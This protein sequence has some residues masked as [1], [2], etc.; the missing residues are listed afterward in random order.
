V[1]V[2]VTKLFDEV[3]DISFCQLC[4]KCGSFSELRFFPSTVGLD[5]FPSAKSRLDG[6]VR[7]CYLC[8][9]LKPMLFT[10]FFNVFHEIF[11]SV[12]K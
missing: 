4:R 3:K 7:P 12:M 10:L 11:Y 8:L 6:V 9:Y 5:F 2:E 1:V